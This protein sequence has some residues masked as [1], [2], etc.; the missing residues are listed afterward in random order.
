MQGEM[1]LGLISAPPCLDLPCSVEGGEIQTAS[2]EAEAQGQ[3]ETPGTCRCQGSCIATTVPGTWLRAPCPTG[4]QV[5]LRRLWH[6]T[7]SQVSHSWRIQGSK[8]VQSR[9]EQIP[10]YVCQSVLCPL[11]SRPSTHLS[12]Y[13]STIHSFICL[14]IYHSLTC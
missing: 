12:V 9:L 5:L 8:G 11:F 1:G 7:G 4:L 3:M 2:A 14:S 10:L 13:P 6:E